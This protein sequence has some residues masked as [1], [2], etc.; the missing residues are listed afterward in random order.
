VPRSIATLPS[1]SPSDAPLL[2]NNQMRT[3]SPPTD[4]GSALLKNI[5]MKTQLT[6]SRGGSCPPS[7]T[8]MRCHRQ[9]MITACTTRSSEAA[10]S[11]LTGNR[12]MAATSAAPSTERTMKATSATLT[13]AFANASS[14]GG[15]STAVGFAATATGLVSSAFGNGASATHANSA[16]FGNGATTTRNDQQV[17]GNGSNTYTMTGIASGNSKA[18]QSGPTQLVTSDAAG[19]LATQSLAGLGIAST[20][21]LSAINNRLNDIDGRVSKVGALGAALA[22]LHPN[23]RAKGDNHIAAAFGT[24]NGQ[25]ALAAGYFRNVGNNVLLSVGVS[26]TGNVWSVNGGSTFSW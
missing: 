14:N 21:D 26:S 9:P 18:A 17:F 11:E 13:A 2:R 23:A 7:N 20:A 19:N 24:Y 3:A 22:G 10:A 1:E 15:A 4:V 8:T 6:A 16:A 25:T 12:R 5:P